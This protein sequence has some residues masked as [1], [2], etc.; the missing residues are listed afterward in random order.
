MTLEDSNYYKD[1]RVLN[2]TFKDTYYYRIYPNTLVFTKHATELLLEGGLINRKDLSEDAERYAIPVKTKFEICNQCNGSGTMVSP[3]IDCN[4]LTSD[5]FDKDPSFE[6]DY[7]SGAYNERC[8]TCLQY[9]G[10]QVVV[11]HCDHQHLISYFEDLIK[12]MRSDYFTQ[13]GE[14]GI[15]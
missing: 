6:S 9:E 7:F 8:S 12:E 4:G 1:P 5:D 3:S 11:T 10:R 14:M 15:W 13:L 2:R